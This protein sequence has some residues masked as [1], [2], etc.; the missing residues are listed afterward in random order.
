MKKLK[1]TWQDGSWMRDGDQSTASAEIPWN[2][3]VTAVGETIVFSDGGRPG[4]TIH[5][6]VPE[7]RLISAVEIEAEGS[8]RA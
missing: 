7:S 6:V 1:V 5:L 8:L 4:S 3:T 2:A